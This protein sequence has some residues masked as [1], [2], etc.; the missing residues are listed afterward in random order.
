MAAFAGRKMKVY[1]KTSA[2]ASYVLLGGLQTAGFTISAEAIDITDMEDAG[3]VTLLDDIGT[4]SFE[5][6]A[7]GVLTTSRML[8]LAAAQTSGTALHLMKFE[9]HSLGDIEGEFFISSFEGSGT[10]GTEAATFSASF[11][12]SGAITFS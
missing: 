12:S 2:A 5:F 4:K 8:T 6:S 11:Q 10:E 9:V 1:H 7:E 3:V